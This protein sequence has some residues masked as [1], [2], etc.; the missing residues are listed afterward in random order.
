MFDRLV[1]GSG[2]GGSGAAQAAER[3]YPVALLERERH[4]NDGDFAETAWR[5]GRHFWIAQSRAEAGACRPVMS[6]T[7]YPKE[8]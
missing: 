2:S 6:I 8:L 5:L 1:I 3:G 4:V 7:P